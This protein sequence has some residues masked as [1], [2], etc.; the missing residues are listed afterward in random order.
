VLLVLLLG[1]FFIAVAFALFARSLLWPRLRAAESL[2]SVDAYGYTGAEA[3]GAAGSTGHSL[4]R[5]HLR[6]S[7]DSVAL[8]LGGSISTRSKK[9]G[10]E[11]LK[12]LLQGAGF[13]T[14]DP[15]RFLGYQAFA[16]ILL[17]VLFIW[18][19]IAGNSSPLL[20]I[21][22]IAVAVLCGWILP[23]TFV[24]RRARMRAERINL[25]MPDLIDMLVASVEA[26]VA[27][28]S[29]LQMATRRLR[30]P[31]GEELRLTLQEQ[32]MGLGLND[33][34]NNMLWR[35]DTLSVRSF[36]RSLVHGEQLGVSIGQTLRNLSTEMRDVRRQV[37]EERAQKAPIKLVFP[38]VL[39]ILPAL[40]VITLGPAFLRFRD[41]FQ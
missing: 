12:K 2:R 40:F 15:L 38:V 7:I 13:Y 14:T 11:N 19:A 17:G 10:E 5:I 6:E 4:P 39:L 37:A 26:G 41:I 21:V 31:L 29:A 16:T 24:K 30:G 36:V 27:F 18:F 9:H 8:R 23:L 34:L 1:L 35:Q 32:S 25:D 28:G 22:L 20:S 3:P 33:A